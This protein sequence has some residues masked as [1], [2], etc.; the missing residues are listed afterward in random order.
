MFKAVENKEEQTRSRDPASAE[1][2]RQ[3]KQWM[4]RSL[5]PPTNAYCCYSASLWAFKYSE[6]KKNLW[7]AQRNKKS[8]KATLKARL[9][10]DWQMAINDTVVFGERALQNG[11]ENSEELL[12]PLAYAKAI[13]GSWDIAESYLQEVNRNPFGWRPV[14]LAA[15]AQQRGDSSVALG[16][17]GDNAEKIDKMNR[18]IQTVIKTS[19][20]YQTP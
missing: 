12:I 7:L 3:S 5:E 20:A 16:F 18:M 11:C 14:L 13:Q 10:K 4:T 19:E 15:A 9:K 2:F 1:L 17:T 8:T 6:K